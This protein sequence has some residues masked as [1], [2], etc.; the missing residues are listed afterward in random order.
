MS[1]Q[2][3]R[4]TS[5]IEKKASDYIP[6]CKDQGIPYLVGSS[7]HGISL[8]VLNFTMP[9]DGL[10][11]FA[12]EG[13]QEM[14]NADYLVFSDNPSATQAGVE[15][16]AETFAITNGQTITAKVDQGAAQTATVNGAVASVTS[17]ND[18]TY[19]L[20]N[21]MTL[22]VS[23]DGGEAQTATFETADFVDIGAAT[24][25]EVAAVL[26]TDILGATST[27][28]SNYVKIAS[29]TVGLSS[30]VQI[31]GGTANAIL[32]F[33]TDEATGTGDAQDL[34]AVTAAELAAVLNT[35]IAGAIASVTEDDKVL[36][37]SDTYGSASFIEVTGGTANTAVGFPTTADQGE[38][39]ASI[40]MSNK[41]AS[42][43]KVN[44]PATGDAVSLLIVGKIAKQL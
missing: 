1:S 14:S 19:V 29:D 3:V 36:F 23:I 16:S 42:G 21:G 41:T 30:S 15:S 39:G 35:D 12:D 18:Q 28:A 17:S 27:D 32:G 33:S 24:A 6:Y 34:S 20:V 26:E 7:Q 37:Q 40:V 11:V 13:L 31:V 22:E 5:Q 10:F 8:Q 44:G 2:S 4:A 38:G 43:F 9:A 25:A